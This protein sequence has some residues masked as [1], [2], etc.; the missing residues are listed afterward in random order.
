MTGM[1]LHLLQALEPTRQ[2]AE[3]VCG[4]TVTLEPTVTM[5]P[6][7]RLLIRIGLQTFQAHAQGDGKAS[8]DKLRADILQVAEDYKNS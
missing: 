2:K 4:E 3:Q 5:G 1:E 6:N 7:F 8:M